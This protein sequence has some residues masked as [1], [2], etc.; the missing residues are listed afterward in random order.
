MPWEE[1]KVY[2]KGNK[3]SDYYNRRL[4]NV[5]ERKKKDAELLEVIKGEDLPWE[6]SRH[7]L[8]KH[9][10]NE[11]MPT[12]F[13]GLELFMQEIPPGSRSGKHRHMAEEV[14]F[15]LEGKGY[16]LHW[17]VNVEI[18]DRYEWKIVEEPK[19]F[20]WEE[21]DLVYIPPNTA[22]QHF[23]AEPSTPARFISVTSTLYQLLGYN[24]LEQL[25]DG[26]QH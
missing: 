17:D 3:K 18:G 11:E 25:E 8:I 5:A 2:K 12:R 15:I 20:D 23:N 6:S 1:A 21:G 4:K 22:H 9:L 13:K 10:M 19:R 26:R 24:D 7:G 16:D 14:L